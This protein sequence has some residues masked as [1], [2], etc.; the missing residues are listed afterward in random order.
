MAA[1]KT[2]NVASTPASQRASVSSATEG[3]QAQ[4][5]TKAQKALKAYRKFGE[6]MMGPTYRVSYAS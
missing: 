4:K 5:A 6:I 2:V 1:Y 3:Q